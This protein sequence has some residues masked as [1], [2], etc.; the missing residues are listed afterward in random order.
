MHSSCR[1]M[2]RPWSWPLPPWRPSPLTGTE[3]GDLRRDRRQGAGGSGAHFPKPGEFEQ[4][5]AALFLFSTRSPV[6][7]QR[8]GSSVG[9]PHSDALYPSGVARFPH[10]SEDASPF[11][12]QE[13]PNARPPA[14]RVLPALPWSQLFSASAPLAFWGEWMGALLNMSTHACLPVLPRLAR[15]ESRA[16]AAACATAGSGH[17]LAP[18][19]IT[20]LLL[21]PVSSP[22][23]P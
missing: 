15:C 16:G 17:S 9:P 1:C 4:V 11:R 23:S 2:C 5:L 21:V 8:P 19:S 14:A 10:R 3:R 7:C 20:R 22:A 13:R 6:L 12:P 18:G